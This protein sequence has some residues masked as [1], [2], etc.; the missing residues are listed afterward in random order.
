[1]SSGIEVDYIGNGV[2]TDVIPGFA[3]VTNIMGAIYLP[4]IRFNVSNFGWVWVKEFT[5][6]TPIQ[7]PYLQLVGMEGVEHY[8]APV[9]ESIGRWK[10]TVIAKVLWYYLTN[11]ADYPRYSSL[12][13]SGVPAGGNYATERTRILYGGFRG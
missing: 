2:F 1:M 7:N 10:I 11:N 3:Q 4:D 6:P 5:L 12:L 13:R 8:F 9:N